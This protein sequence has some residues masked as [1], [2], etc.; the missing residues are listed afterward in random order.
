MFT[1]GGKSL[2]NL[3]GEILFSEWRTI[4]R[5]N[6]ASDK[7]DSINSGMFIC[8]N[9]GIGECFSVSEIKN[10]KKYI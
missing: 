5:E 1:P 2:V 7:K 3:L 8:K 4:V 6:F 9:M 10:M